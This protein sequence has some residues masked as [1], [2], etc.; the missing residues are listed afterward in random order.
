MSGWFAASA[1]SEADLVLVVELALGAGLI[2]GLFLARA[3]HF[4]VHAILQSSIVLVNIPII[5]AWMIPS[6]RSFV[7][8]GIAASWNQ[9]FYLLP[10]MMLVVGLAA[11]LLGLFVILAAGT[12][13]LPARLRFT[14]YKLW[15]RTVLGLW[16]GV[17]VL[18]LLTYYYWYVAS[19]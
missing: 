19:G 13:W 16:W 7:V 3:R 12:H 6:Y 10:S 14:N 11:E 4:R 15:M 17:L 1:P 18:G 5:L 2:G 9:P 8:P